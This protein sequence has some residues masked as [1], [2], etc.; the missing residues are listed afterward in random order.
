VADREVPVRV[1]GRPA[2]DGLVVTPP[3]AW[4]PTSI[5]TIRTTRRRRPSRPRRPPKKKITRRPP[6]AGLWLEL[7]TSTPR[8]FV[9]CGSAR[10]RPLDRVIRPPVRVSIIEPCKSRGGP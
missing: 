7:S 4:S 1:K 8:V 10:P 2:S 3:V 6:T 9:A 5:T